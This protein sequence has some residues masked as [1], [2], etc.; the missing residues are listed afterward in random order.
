MGRCAILTLTALLCCLPA[1]RPASAAQDEKIKAK[2]ADLLDNKDVKKRRKAISDLEQDGVGRF[3][4]IMQA[5]QVALEKDP[6]PIV[7][8]EVAAVLGRAGEDAKEAI[9]SLAYSLR[10]DKDDK[11]RE[12]AGRALLQ[13]VPASRRALQQL[14]EALQDSYAPTRAVAAE[15]IKTLGEHSKTAVPQLVDFLKAGKDKKGDAPARMYV[16][17]ALGRVGAEGAKGTD[18]LCAVLED[19]GEDNSVR[20]AAAESLGRIGLDAVGAAKPLANVVKSTKNPV[21]FRLAAVRA[22]G[23]VEGETKDVWPALKIALEDN[24]STMR[25]LAVRATTPYAHEEPEAVKTLTKIARSIDNNVE[26]R[27]AAIQELGRVGKDA[28]T[29]VND[30]RFLEENDERDNIRL[31]AAQARKK[32]EG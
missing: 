11:T 29:A 28:K 12:Q 19:G 26:V 30:L 22:L 20:E 24:D 4:E 17:L 14:A 13:M 1:L 8:Q 25:L 18:A 31:E 23:K 2:I 7:R 16:A 5:M 6:E 10:H 32:I 3:K 15:A 9:P 27:V 21:S